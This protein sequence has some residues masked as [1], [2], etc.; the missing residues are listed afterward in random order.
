MAK[1]NSKTFNPQAFGIYVNK[2]PQLNKNEL[3]K[4][5][6]LRGN[7]EIRNAFSDQSGTAYAILPMFGILD[8]DPLNY[9]GQT[10]ITA[11]ETNT[12][13]RGVVVVGRAKA[14]IETDF[15]EDITGGAG[16]HFLF[17]DG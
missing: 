11:T 17:P 6:A 10:D 3:I 2:I 13:E 7:S 4:S 12:F 8:G 14:W 9:D 16:S 5:K 1:F 15:A